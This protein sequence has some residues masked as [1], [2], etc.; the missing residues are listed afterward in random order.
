M[1]EL[2]ISDI[3]AKGRAYVAWLKEDQNK[4]MQ[5]YIEKYGANNVKISLSSPGEDWQWIDNYYDLEN[6]KILGIW[7]KPEGQI[8]TSQKVVDF[9]S[10]P[11]VIIGIGAIVF[12][13]LI[14]G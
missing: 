7:V 4:R 14:R 10:N 11:I 8:S 2:S 13:K 5:R 3:L 6:L 12:I 1:L 9:L